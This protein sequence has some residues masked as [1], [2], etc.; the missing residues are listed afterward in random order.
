MFMNLPLF[1]IPKNGHNPK[2]TIQYNIEKSSKL[3]K[4]LHLCHHKT[5]IKTLNDIKNQFYCLKSPTMPL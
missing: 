1:S 3:T 2:N 5:A 4:N